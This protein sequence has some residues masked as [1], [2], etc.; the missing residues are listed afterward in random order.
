MAYQHLMVKPTMQKMATLLSQMASV[1]LKL[2]CE[3][4]M[5][6]AA[7]PQYHL[8]ITIRMDALLAMSAVAAVAMVAI[9]EAY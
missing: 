2:L 5:V 4:E 3:E 7:V 1:N 6:V 8:T 9:S